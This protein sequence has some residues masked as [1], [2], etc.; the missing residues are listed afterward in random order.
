VNASLDHV[1]AVLRYATEDQTRRA[2]EHLRGRI[3]ARSGSAEVARDQ[4]VTV[5]GRYERTEP[6]VAGEMLADA[7]LPALRAGGPGEAVRLARRAV[8]LSDEFGSGAGL[9]ADVA[10]GTALI[11]AG[12]YAE[13]AA[14]LDDAQEH[15][16]Q[17]N[18]WQQLAYLG[19]GLGLAGRYAN[20]RRVLTKVIDEARA[21]GAMSILPYALTRLADTHI[22]TGR[23]SAASVALHE[24]LR[25]ARE[26]GQPSDYGL[27]LGVLAWLAGARG[28]AEECELH[29]REALQIALRLGAG[30]RLDRAS[31]AMGMLELGRGR[32]EDAIA[33]LQAACR[34]QDELGWSDAGRTPHRRPDLVEA[35]ALAG[36]GGEAREALDRF[37]LDAE[38]GK[39]PSAL[40]AVARCRALLAEEGDLDDVF[41]VARA[42]GVRAWGPFDQARTDLLY[43]I[44][45]V[46]A[47]RTQDAMPVLRGALT[48]FE[49]LAAQ[50]WAERARNGILAVGGALPAPRISLAE[51]LT[52]QELE[53]ALAAADGAS[54]V[55]IAELL[56]LGPRT[57]QLQL[58]SA[59]IRLGLD[60]P[61]GLAEVVREASADVTAV[62]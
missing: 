44:R 38:H 40:A 14:R 26:T 33:H 48:T 31:T 12:D 47:G 56:L 16:E 4:L 15:A 21:T 3:I 57:V 24:A 30:S 60:S 8:Q 55:Q 2:A 5:A 10:L 19:A 7:V 18:D 41:A 9:S 28:Q 36:R 58:A 39:R 29:G 1:D 17:T 53:V 11:F 59:A 54:P 42:A 23:W 22:E 27:A 50:S 34:L 6:N 62:V 51:R 43:G 13:G 45:L 61:A 49:D 46:D 32:P 52:P 20:A 37:R 25:L 35:Y